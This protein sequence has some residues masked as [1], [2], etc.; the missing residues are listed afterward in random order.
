MCLLQKISP[1]GAYSSVYLNTKT[2]S[3][4]TGHVAGFTIE[5]DGLLPPEHAQMNMP[6]HLHVSVDSK[7]D[8][9]VQ[10]VIKF[11]TTAIEHNTLNHRESSLNWGLELFWISFVA[12]Y[13][14]FPAGYNWPSEHGG[15]EPDSGDDYCDDSL[16]ASFSDQHTVYTSSDTDYDDLWNQFRQQLGL[17][18]N[19]LSLI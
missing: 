1:S 19:P 18:Y 8:R 3:N 2:Q 12:T 5:F 6:L 17:F 10:P 11:T 15:N 16:R 9:Y 14:K 13:P 7:F 4:A